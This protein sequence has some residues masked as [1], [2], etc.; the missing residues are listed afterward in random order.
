MTW[1][2]EALNETVAQE[3]DSPPEDMRARFVRLSERI[4]RVGLERLG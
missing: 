1:R 3:I 4:E 2:V